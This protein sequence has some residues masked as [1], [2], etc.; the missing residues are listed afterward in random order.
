MMEKQELWDAS[1]EE[2]RRGYRIVED[3]AE[4]LFCGQRYYT[5]EIYAQDERWVLGE[6]KMKSHV[7]NVHGSPLAML[8]KLRPEALGISAMQLEMLQ[9]F[10][11]GQS[12]QQIAKE[13]GVTLSTIRNYRFKL[14]EKQK[15]AQLF[16][17][18]MTLLNE[19][20]G[21]SIQ[22]LSDTALIDAHAA[23]VM[24]DERYELTE[25]EKETILKTYFD[26][27]GALKEMPAKAKRKLAVL[28][29][30][31]ENFKPEVRYT[32]K[33]IN[34]LLQRIWPDHV[35]LRRALIEYG[36]LERT[37]DGSAYW[38]K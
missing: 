29:Q 36:F 13:K 28:A 11:C 9:A 34:T 24:R 21:H 15:Q 1:A 14:R 2:M 8:L 4:C 6:R 20:S 12:D 22:Q 33:Q 17:M 3:E 16:V 35:Y 18:M 10:A 7:K 32:E 26:P 27:Q 5:Q 19:N 31:A 23:A 30:I 37:A 25:K 38:R